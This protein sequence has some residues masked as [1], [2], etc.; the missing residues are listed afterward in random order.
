MRGVI[1]PA[2]VAPLMPGIRGPMERSLL[3]LAA[4][5]AAVTLPSVIRPADEEP[6][7]ASPAAQLE[8]HELV[9]PR[10]KDENWT[11]ASGSSIVA[12]YRL[13]I[14]WPYMR[15]QAPTW[16]L[17]RFIRGP[18]LQQ[19]TLAAPI[20]GSSPRRTRWSPGYQRSLPLRRP[21]RA[22]TSASPEVGAS[23]CTRTTAPLSRAF[24]CCRRRY[25]VAVGSLPEP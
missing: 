10:R 11:A 7:Q 5:L 24:S 12:S 21:S 1:L 16:A 20:P 22:R 15:V 3:E 4:I 17:L 19:V 18:H 14:R 6:P 25:R 23:A 2:L 13:S 8:D 9:H